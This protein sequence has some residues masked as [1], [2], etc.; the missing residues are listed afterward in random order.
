MPSPDCSFNASPSYSRP[1]SPAQMQNLDGSDLAQSSAQYL[2]LPLPS[3]S[4][5]S[6]PSHPFSQSI[7]SPLLL[8]DLNWEMLNEGSLFAAG[9]GGSSCQVGAIT[10]TTNSLITTATFTT[11]ITATSVTTIPCL[12]NPVPQIAGARRILR[13]SLGDLEIPAPDHGLETHL[14]SRISN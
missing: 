14:F 10:G 11:T 3:P 4:V 9:Y 2:P 12:T 6:S 8:E 7:S 5:I 13:L 1:S